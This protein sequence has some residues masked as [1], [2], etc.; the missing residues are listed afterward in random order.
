VVAALLIGFVLAFVGSMP[1]AGPIAALLV[2]MGLEGQRRAG[3]YVAI[4]AALSESAYA[5]IAYLGLTA[6]LGRFP[7]LLPISRVVGCV[8]LVAL[9][10]YFLVRPKTKPRERATDAPSSGKQPRYGHLA[11]GLSITLFN[12]TLIVTWTAA[13]SAAQSTGLLRVHAM[14]AFPFAAG[15]ATGIVTWFSVLLWLLTRFQK[16]L[17]PDLLDRVIRVMGALLVTAG[18]GFGLRTLLTWHTG[19]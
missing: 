14:D 5:C 2:S 18:L 10:T 13:V 11:L 15:V 19:P 16:K 7:L 6:V 17:K 12:P 3:L 9:G 8:I 4:G 1:I